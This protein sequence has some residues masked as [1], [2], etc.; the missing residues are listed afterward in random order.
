MFVFC[1]HFHF[2]LISGLCPGNDWGFSLNERECRSIPGAYPLRLGRARFN[3]IIKIWLFTAANARLPLPN[4]QTSIFFLVIDDNKCRPPPLINRPG[5]ICIDFVL[6][7]FPK[8]KSRGP[9]SY[10]IAG[11]SM[12]VRKQV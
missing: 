12:F 4:L 2:R 6:N 9:R 3:W 11:Q 8:K 7:K 5:I 1:L 10:D